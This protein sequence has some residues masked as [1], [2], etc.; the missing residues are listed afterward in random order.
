V[1]Y[2]A[3]SLSED[4]RELVAD[5]SNGSNVETNTLVFR[6]G[7]GLEGGID[8]SEHVRGDWGG[9]DSLEA[10]GVLSEVDS[11]EE[12]SF[13]LHLVASVVEN[14]SE[15]MEEE[16]GIR[17]GGDALL[18]SVGLCEASEEVFSVNLSRVVH[19]WE[20]GIAS[21]EDLAEVSQHD[22]GVVCIFRDGGEII[23]VSSE[24]DQSTSFPEVFAWLQE[25]LSVEGSH[26]VGDVALDGFLVDEDV[27]ADLDYQLLGVLEDLN[28]FSELGDVDCGCLGANEQVVSNGLD[29][30]TNI[31]EALSDWFE[32][33]LYEEV[34]CVVE[35]VSDSAGV[36][37]ASR[38]EIQV[39][40]VAGTDEDTGC[41]VEDFFGSHSRVDGDEEKG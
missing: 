15:L 27:F 26:S 36:R 34:Y 30:I 41:H 8:V 21:T 9:L 3:S 17:S 22:V 5:L 19:S 2:T 16:G 35:V 18:G 24:E 10:W 11:L 37:N 38:E 28:H 40:L 13:L 20:D 7:V 33:S 14:E 29:G 39:F 23:A 32:I 25:G 6:D 4:G 12:S 1:G 31:V